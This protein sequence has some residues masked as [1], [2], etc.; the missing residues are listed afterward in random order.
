MEDLQAYHN[1]YVDYHRKTIQATKKHAVHQAKARYKRQ[2]SIKESTK[3]G[4]LTSRKAIGCNRDR[5]RPSAG[6]LRIDR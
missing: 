4:Q 3:R 2:R 1:S 5:R 6:V